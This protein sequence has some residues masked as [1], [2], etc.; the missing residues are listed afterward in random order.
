MV[1]FKSEIVKVSFKWVYSSITDE[2]LMKLDELIN[3]RSKEGWELANYSFMGGA[4]GGFGRG[5]LITFRR[6]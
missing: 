4:G 5:I 2:E 6:D 3:K 1:R